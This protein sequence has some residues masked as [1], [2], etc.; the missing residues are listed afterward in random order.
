MGGGADNTYVLAPPDR[1]RYLLYFSRR[2]N[3]GATVKGPF[4]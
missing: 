2:C 4:T 1:T 3:T